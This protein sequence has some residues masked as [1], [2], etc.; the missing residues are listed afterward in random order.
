MSATIEAEPTL[1]D[2]DQTTVPETVRRALQLRKRDKIKYVIRT[3]GQAM[4][5]C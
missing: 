1:T 5:W 4:R 3:I 2:R